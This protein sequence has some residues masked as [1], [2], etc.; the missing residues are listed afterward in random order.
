MEKPNP[1]GF[2]CLSYATK[3]GEGTNGNTSV[4]HLSKSGTFVAACNKQVVSV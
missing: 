3:Q 1:N 4:M 2:F